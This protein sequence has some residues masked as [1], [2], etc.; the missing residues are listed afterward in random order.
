MYYSFYGI[1]VNDTQQ[2]AIMTQGKK[3]ALSKTGDHN[4]DVERMQYEKDKENIPATVPGYV[5]KEK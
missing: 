2:L 4:L 3:H 1:G 5:N